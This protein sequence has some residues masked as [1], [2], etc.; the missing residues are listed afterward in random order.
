MSRCFPLSAQ[1]VR[2][3]TN[4]G[5]LGTALLLVALIGAGCTA[6][7]ATPAAARPAPVV[8]TAEPATPPIL[9]A[10]GATSTAEAMP[11][12]T[13]TVAAAPAVTSTGE[14]TPGA[15]PTGSASA[16]SGA[17]LVNVFQKPNF[18]RFLVDDKGM[19]LYLFTKD[20]PDTSNCYGSCA[21][22]W[23]PLLTN[24]TPLAGPGVDATLL[25]ATA[26]TDGKTQ[27]TYNHMP[28]Y[29][30]AK[31]KQAGDITGQGVGGVWFVV[32]PRGRGMTGPFKGTPRPGAPAPAA[33]ATPAATS[34]Y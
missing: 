20:T 2:A 1:R 10:A 30:F 3:A 8:A 29:H 18:G 6:P 13:P 23:P 31:D 17:A 7:A 26:R 22:A 33:N 34:G 28:L 24:G 9:P 14:A 5:W 25:G 27:V 19:T 12:S 15:K 11:G 4:R 16:I 21:A 32:S